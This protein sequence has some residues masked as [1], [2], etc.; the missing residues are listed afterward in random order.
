MATLGTWL[1]RTREARGSSLQEAASATRIR[2]RYLEM[3]EAGEFVALPGGEAQARGFLR[4]YARY[5]GLSPDEVIARYEQERRGA[6]PAPPVLSPSPQAVAPPPPCQPQP[7]PPSPRGKSALLLALVG[8]GLTALVVGLIAAGHFLASHAAARK[9]TATAMAGPSGAGSSPLETP[10]P[11]FPAGPEIIVALQAS[12]HVWV[13]VTAD[14]A[15][16]FQGILAPG[17]SESWRGQQAIVIETGNG[18]ALQA[19]VNGQAVGVLGERGQIVRRAW[20]PSG[21]IAPPTP[22]PTP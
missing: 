6:I 22:V 17:Q 1:R 18:A 12:E 7:E 20:S 19:I 13:R 3:L 9:A 2:A 5:L 21:E 11:T 4:L 10:T 15:V 14:G 8:L 16:A